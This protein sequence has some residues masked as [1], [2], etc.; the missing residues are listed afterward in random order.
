[1]ILKLRYG[2]RR[3][4][5]GA[6]EEPM[7]IRR[8]ISKSMLFLSSDITNKTIFSLESGEDVANISGMVVNPNNLKIEA[9]YVSSPFITYDAV[10]FTE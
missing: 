3:A 4:L 5:D 10:V 9:F 2:F 6:T 7:N 8:E 1:M